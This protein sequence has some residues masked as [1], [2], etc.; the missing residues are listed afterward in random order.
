MHSEFSIAVHA[1]VYLSHKATML[2]S[3]ALAESICAHSVRVR[4]VLAPLS[5]AG[6]LD[7]KVGAHGGYT[8][9]RPA[10]D[11]TL[12]DLAEL[13]GTQFVSTSWK[14]GD[15]ERECLVAS[16]MAEIIDGMCAELDALCK[17]RLAHTTIADIEHT[18]FG[19]LL[20][21]RCDDLREQIAIVAGLSGNQNDCDVSAKELRSDALFARWE[22]R[23]LL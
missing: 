21:Q 5:H 18:I 6:I 14:S 12:A 15:V 20:L 7:V 13:L 4:N 17:E 19:T 16:G 23:K 2:S 8:M 1:L 22:E 3:E 9:V 11:I 10:A